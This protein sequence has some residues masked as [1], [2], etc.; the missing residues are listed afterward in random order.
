MVAF[1][2]EKEANL[3]NVIPRY[4]CRN[5]NTVGVHWFRSSFDYKDLDKIKTFISGFYG[6]SDL[7]DYGNWSYD[8]RLFWKSGVSLNFDSDPE[9][10][11]RAHKGRMTLDVPG[12]AC[13]ELTAPD[14]LL[15]LEGCAYFGCKCTRIDVFWD[16]Y[17]RIVV[18]QDIQIV[19]DKNDFSMFR[20]ASKNSTRNRTIKKNNGL[21]YDAVTFGRRGSKGSGKYLRIYD[22]KLESK[23][24]F[25]C[26]RWECEFSQGKAQKVFTILAGAAGDLDVFATVC[27]ALIGGC[28]N[29]VHRTGEKHIARLDVY[30][31]W[32][33]IIKSLGKLSVRVAKKKNNLT[34]MIY[35]QE[36][37]VSPS[38]ACIRKAFA[39]E[40][41]F[42][43]WIKNLL[44]VGG[45][46]MSNRQN[47]IAKQNAGRLVYDWNRDYKE[48]SYSEYVSA[49]CV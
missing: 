49:M 46:R 8:R 16:D 33:L 42:Y 34:G 18:P 21:I 2:D 30:E 13:D 28:V 38:L 1:K 7:D 29:F 35:W 39:T 32:K 6:E 36:R 20:I 23:D 47:Q 43:R 9:R 14:L 11:E 45:S 17:S 24:K 19:I 31:W 41:D 15:L 4:S 12:D 37:Q 22:K 40:Q 44:D 27:G 25:D 26:I 10:C 48:K 3:G 5:N